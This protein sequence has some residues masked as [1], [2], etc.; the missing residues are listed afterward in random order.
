MLIEHYDLEVFTPPCEPGAERHSAIARLTVDISA[1]LP[2]LNATL[3][4]AIYHRASGTLT[5]KKGGRNITF[6][7]Y[8]IAVSNLEDRSE[9]QRVIDGLVD[10]VNRTWERRSE[11]TPDDT[12]RQRP[13]PLTVYNLL[14]RTNCKA[15]GEPSCYTF[16]LKLVAA[17]VSLERCPPLAEPAWA[18]NR[19][20]LEAL[21]PDMPAIG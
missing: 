20:R 9:A 19:A 8:Q 14:P 21:L 12:E 5:W 18:E 2:Y 7:A 16:A 1:A 4:G 10:L 13:A 6:G 15:C 3:R 17:Q 11:I